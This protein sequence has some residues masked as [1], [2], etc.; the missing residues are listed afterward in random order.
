M[1]IF[2]LVSFYYCKSTCSNCKNVLFMSY[3][4]YYS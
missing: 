2:I 3:G 1:L 4:C